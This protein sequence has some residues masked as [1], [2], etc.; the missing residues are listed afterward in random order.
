M[1]VTG[2]SQVSEA[3]GA[4]VRSL[5]GSGGR[6][7]PRVCRARAGNLRVEAQDDADGV[8]QILRRTNE[9]SA[10]LNS[11]GPDPVDFQP[12][13]VAFVSGWTLLRCDHVTP[14]WSFSPVRTVSGVRDL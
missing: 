4:G 12:R 7:R 13:A 2:F 8:R 5:C 1:R 3:V 11:V 14:V 10:H 9:R 6:R